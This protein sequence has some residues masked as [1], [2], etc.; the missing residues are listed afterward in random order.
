M[1]PEKR[2][3]R[4]DTVTE[5]TASKE[6]DEKEATKEDE[7]EE[8]T[9]SSQAAQPSKPTPLNK[10]LKSKTPPLLEGSEPDPEEYDVSHLSCLSRAD[11]SFSRRAGSGE[12]ECCVM[13]R[14][15]RSNPSLEQT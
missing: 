15:L 14:P 3:S 9:N 13:I 8:E 12:E 2:V 4:L 7:V 11:S 10:P 6:N 1:Q 5:K